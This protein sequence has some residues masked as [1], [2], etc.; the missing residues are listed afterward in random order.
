MRILRSLPASLA[1]LWTAA[2]AAAGQEAASGVPTPQPARVELSASAGVAVPGGNLRGVAK[3]G[4]EARARLGYRVATS[5]T[6]YAGYQYTR[7]PR[8]DSVGGGHLAVQAPEAGITLG[9]RATSGVE[10]L[11]EV[12]LIFPRFSYAGASSSRGLGARA[13]LGARVAAGRGF[14]VV[15][16]WD[17]ETCPRPRKIPGGPP[18]PPWW[19]TA[20]VGIQHA[21]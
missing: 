9:R 17:G 14:S 3:T 4:Y 7:F 5:V 12:G 19:S 15:A 16:E 6:I 21:L 1:V 2:G 20:S 13:G 10:P 11:L 18:G 8:Q